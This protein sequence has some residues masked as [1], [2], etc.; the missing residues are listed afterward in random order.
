M[1]VAD[2]VLGIAFRPAT[3]RATGENDRVICLQGEQ[4][5]VSPIITTACKGWLVVQQPRTATLNLEESATRMFESSLLLLDRVWNKDE[6]CM[7]GFV[8]Q[9]AP[10]R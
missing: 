7:V 5:T 9:K 6:F 8:L 3:P 2:R 4:L 1:A 10:V